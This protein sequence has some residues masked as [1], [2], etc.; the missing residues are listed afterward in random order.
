MVHAFQPKSM[1]G[2]PTCFRLKMTENRE[3]TFLLL[4]PICEA[5]QTIRFLFLFGK[6][7][8]MLMLAAAQEVAN[9]RACFV[10]SR[11]SLEMLSGQW[12][13]SIAVDPVDS[14]ISC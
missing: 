1:G 5:V 7:R 4:C 11:F 9:N 3:C 12:S 2:L 13:D 6:L 8:I 10:A 14:I